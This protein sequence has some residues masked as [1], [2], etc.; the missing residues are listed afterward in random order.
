MDYLNTIIFLIII[1]MVMSDD[2]NHTPDGYL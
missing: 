1:L 2:I